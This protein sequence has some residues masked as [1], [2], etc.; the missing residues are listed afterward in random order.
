MRVSMRVST[1]A[2]TRLPGWARR[3]AQLAHSRGG[4]RRAASRA[5]DARGVATRA[6]LTGHPVVYHP[7]FAISPLPGAQLCSAS[8]PFLRAS[9]P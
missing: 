2:L 7:D 5:A 6:A 9:L 3:G 1:A 4:C 8:A